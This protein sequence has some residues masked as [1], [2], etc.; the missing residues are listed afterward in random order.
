MKTIFGF[1]FFVL[2]AISAFSTSSPSTEEEI[3]L[4]VTLWKD[5]IAALSWST[6]TGQKN[7]GYNVY[8]SRTSHKNY[9]PLNHK[10]IIQL[11][12]G[13]GCTEKGN[14]YFIVRPVISEKPLV[15]GTGSNEI[16]ITVPKDHPIG[17]LPEFFTKTG[18][19]TF[20]FK[21]TH[22][23]SIRIRVMILDEN[24]DLVCSLNDPVLASDAQ[25]MTW[26]QKNDK[27]EVVRDGSYILDVQTLTK[28][29][30]VLAESKRN[31]ETSD[32][33][34]PAMLQTPTLT[35]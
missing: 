8:Y 16:R 25:I 10:P 32:K 6:K 23:Q 3:K 35:P 18:P 20:S 12:M 30:L 19:H 27:G 28:E 31:F 13:M 33:K 26:N 29:G 15:E 17:P 24:E 9:V 1:V 21:T 7:E 4:K 11:G 5:W 34:A 22:L 2:I 14:Y